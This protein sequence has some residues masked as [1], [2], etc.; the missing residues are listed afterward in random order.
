[1]WRLASS[2]TKRLSSVL[3]DGIRIYAIGDVH[4]CAD[5][6]GQTLSS[7]DAD[8]RAY[9]IPRAVRV[10]IGDYID[11]GPASSEV[12]DR[13]II[14]GAAHECV[15]LK[16]NHDTY[17]LKFLENPG[18]LGEWQQVGGLETLMAYGLRPSFN[19][20]AAKQGELAKALDSVLP[21][22]H[23]RFLSGLQLSFS[24]GDFF[25]VHAGVKP[26]VPLSQQRE[27]D[28]V[29]IRNEFICCKKD[30]GKYIVHGHTPVLEPDIRPNRINID[31][32]G[33]ASGRLT[34]LR[35]ELGEVKFIVN[36]RT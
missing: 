22:S 12:L 13:L 19:S 34:C 21:E 1:M 15:F 24:C 3:P 25:F 7:I 17:L 27:E 14:Y 9:P 26:G 10:F 36:T 8:L 31:T 2:K 18:I 23:R 4:G 29:W 5:L 11:R 32:G 33:Y 30:F 6:L 20:S 16:G 28:L 35:V